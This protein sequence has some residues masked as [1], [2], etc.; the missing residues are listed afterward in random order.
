MAVPSGCERRHEFNAV[1]FCYH[2]LKSHSPTSLISCPVVSGNSHTVCTARLLGE[3]GWV[4]GRKKGPVKCKEVCM[5]PHK[6]AGRQAG[7]QGTD[8]SSS[9][10]SLHAQVVVAVA[11]AA[12]CCIA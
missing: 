4:E 5:Q 3:G 6:Q 11:V 10:S 8:R 2:S 7:R 12:V 1:P 9:T